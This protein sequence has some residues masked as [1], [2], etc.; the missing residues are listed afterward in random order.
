[1]SDPRP[2]GGGPAGDDLVPQPA[3]RRSAFVDITPLRASPAFARLWAGQAISGIGSQMT[4]VAV[5]LDV[6]RLTSSTLA[7]AGVALFALVPMIVAG[8]YGGMLADAFDRRRVALLAAV[9]AWVSTALLAVLA[10]TG[11]DSVGALYTLAT[12]NAV[13]ATVVQTTRSAIFPRILPRELL[14]AAAALSG[15][16]TGVMV[17]VGPA[18]AG[19]LVASVGFGW[20]YSI[21]VVLFVAAF[22][23]IASLPR[24]LPEGE[25]H[26][27]GLTSLRH[28]FAFL[29][30]A[31]NIRASFLIDIAAMTFG[32]PRVLFP[33]VGV[34]V[35]G[36]GPVTVGVLTAAFA[37]G[38]LLASVF[39]GRLGQVRWQGRAIARAVQSYG[40][41]TALFGV[42]LLVA[43]LTGGT[44]GQDWA[45]VD[46]AGLGLASLALMG[47]GV[48]DEISAIFRSTMLQTAVPDNMRGRLQGVFTVVVTGGPRI[49]DLYVGALSVVAALWLPPLVGGLAIVVAAG[50]ILRFVHSFRAYDALDPKP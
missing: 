27:P 48:S 34:L 32:Q 14:P 16:T 1:M 26:R 15:I 30:R 50:V 28:G 13:S 39:S 44:V 19:V 20:T 6:Y 23:G 45:R 9:I 3:R 17:T 2:N 31:P 37:I 24:I 18:L 5:G 40:V 42:V 38:S 10:W 36:G 29:R 22:L 35:L 47:A 46:L 43:A 4:V 12:V 49:G 33:A 7:V 11:A 8:L 21:D 41:F 25:V